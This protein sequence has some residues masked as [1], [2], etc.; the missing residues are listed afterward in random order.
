[1]E[2]NKEACLVIS[3]VGAVLLVAYAGVHSDP[4]AFALVPN[5]GSSSS[6]STVCV[7]DQPCYSMVCID[8]QP[9]QVSETPNIQSPYEDS[10]DDVEDSLE[11]ISEFD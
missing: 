11:D 1:M 10:L 8:N 7:D 6:S 4:K 5:T 2:Y 3:F 9:C